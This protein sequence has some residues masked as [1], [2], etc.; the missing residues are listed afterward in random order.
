RATGCRA[1]R[2]PRRLSPRRSSRCV[3]PPTSRRRWQVPIAG[4]SRVPQ[5]EPDS[6]SVPFS[7]NRPAALV[8]VLAVHFTTPD[9]PLEVLREREIPFLGRRHSILMF[10]QGSRVALQVSAELGQGSA[11]FLKERDI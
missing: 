4:S 1:S 9:Q 7:A 3:D 6:W 8:A 10:G 5:I 11:K 2:R